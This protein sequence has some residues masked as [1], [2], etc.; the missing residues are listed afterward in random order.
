MTPHLGE[1]VCL[2]LPC[3]RPRSDSPRK[4]GVP[5][6]SKRNSCPSVGSSGE[7]FR[8][9]YRPP[10]DWFYIRPCGSA[11]VGSHPD[12]PRGS[13]TKVVVSPPAPG[14]PWRSGPGRTPPTGEAC[15][16]PAARPRCCCGSWDCSCCGSRN[17]CSSCCCSSSRRA[18]CGLLPSS[19]DGSAPSDRRHPPTCLPI[20]SIRSEANA[21]CFTSRHRRSFASL[22]HNRRRSTMFCA[23]ARD[24]FRYFP[25]TK[26]WTL[27]KRTRS[28][29][30]IRSAKVK[31]YA[32]GNLSVRSEY[33]TVRS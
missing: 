26:S 22:F 6:D 20:S 9:G 21:Y 3:V 29:S 27:S 2:G 5:R 12:S 31:R 24:S 32:L 28:P 25:N 10:P 23:R 4:Q 30:C 13:G 18:G 17:G 15:A 8:Q 14:R 16:A 1:I 11:P 7:G 33:Q 19:P